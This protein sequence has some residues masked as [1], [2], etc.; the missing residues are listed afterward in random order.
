MKKIEHTPFIW[1]YL[2]ITS[3]EEI[4]TIRNACLEHVHNNDE[5][6]ERNRSDAVRNSSYNLTDAFSPIQSNLLLRQKMYDVD[7]SLSKIYQEAQDLYIKEN[8]LFRYTL[9][10]ANVTALGTSYH[11]RNY[12]VGDEYDYHVD[13]WEK[14]RFILSG[15]LY[16]NDDFEGGDTH[17]LV[18]DIHVK[19]IKNSIVM[20]PCGPYFIHSSVPVKKGTKNIIWSCFDRLVKGSPLLQ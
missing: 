13:L 18:D 16:L 15:I 11:F 20:C 1:Q 7:Q 3:N 17:Y 9:E 4:E 2:D 6:V 12:D 19:P 14:G 10:A 8:E 5:F